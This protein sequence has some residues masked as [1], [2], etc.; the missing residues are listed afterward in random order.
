MA[1]ALN[2]KQA[3]SSFGKLPL[4]DEH[5][6]PNYGFGTSTRAKADNVYLGKLTEIAN[7]AK[8]G[9]GPC[10]GYEDKIKF[11]EVGEKQLVT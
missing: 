1:N 8:K 4:D 9:P 11:S 10:Y 6:S 5:T 2:S 7:I 3:H